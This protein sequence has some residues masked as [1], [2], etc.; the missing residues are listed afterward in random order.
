MKYLSKW[1]TKDETLKQRVFKYF[2]PYSILCFKIFTFPINGSELSS[3][4]IEKLA[5]YIYLSEGGLNTRNP[6]GIFLNR[7][8]NYYQQKDSNKVICVKIIKR[9]YSKWIKTD[10]EL[11]FINFLGLKYCPPSVDYIGHL[12]WVYN[13][14]YFARKDKIKF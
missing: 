6:Y 5:H 13:V 12:N 14:N 7:H 1:F 8:L 2:I 11:S 10:K 3:Y 4:K 9:E